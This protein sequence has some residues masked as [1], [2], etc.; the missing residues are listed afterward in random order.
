MKRSSCRDSLYLGI[1]LLA[2]TNSDLATA[3]ESTAAIQ[4]LEDITVT[5]TR[6]ASSTFEVP[7]TTSIVQ[8]RELAERAPASLRDALEEVPGLS[9]SGAGPWEA[10]PILRGFGG[11]RVLVLYDNDRVTNLWAGR[12]PL[13]PF[14]DV[15]EIERIEVIKGPASVLYG[16]DALGGVINIITKDIAYAK[17]AR[18]QMDQRFDSR[19][20]SADNGWYGGYRL[21]AGGHGL[22]MRVSVAARDHQD[23]RDGKGDELNHSQFEGQYLNVKTHYWLA[24]GQR[25]SASVRIND[26]DDFGVPQK[27]PEAPYSHFTV[28]D[29]RTYKLGYTGEALGWVEQLQA[30]AF[31]VDQD[32]QF[33]GQ[34]PSAS[35]P[36]SNR[37]ENAIDSGGIGGSLQLRLV[38]LAGHGLLAG[39]ELLRETTDSAETQRIRRD[40]NGSLARQLTFQP[41]PDAYRDYLGVFL[42]DTLQVAESLRLVAGGRY[43]YFRTDADDVTFTDE[44]F[45]KQGQRQQ[46]S[47]AVNEFSREQDSATTFSLGL[48]YKL[49][50]AVHLRS[51][52]ASAFRAPDIFE[53][54]STRGGGSRLIIGNPG[55][56]P[57]RTYSLEGGIDVRNRHGRGQ[58]SVY[59]NRVDDYIDLAI[60]E[61]SFLGE[62]PTYRYQNIQDAE[63]YG[64]DGDTSLYLTPRLT[65]TGTLAWV[66]G[67]DRDSGARLSSIPPLNGSVGLRF[68]AHWQAFRYWLAGETRLYQS[69]SNPAAGEQDTPGYATVALRLGIAR[70]HWGPLEDVRLSVN[71]ENLFDRAYQNHLRSG[72]EPFL[73][74]PGIN[75]VTALQVGF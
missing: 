73:Y 30:K 71:V 64:L 28:F 40:G 69:Q 72:Q 6:T 36:V 21:S 18:W 3:E 15:G 52:L 38:P 66:E 2:L 60:Q 26:I 22:G 25:I 42:Q 74:E 33:A 55:L 50:P 37:K 53:R 63:L 12:A 29:T 1:C 14:L 35:K 58:L 54:Y 43:D 27:D 44:R 32:R 4:T 23:Y 24:E 10:Q 11:S 19:Y 62:I 9:F 49:T 75:A 8:R 16:S 47:S 59:Y 5:A 65:L 45:N 34:F 17:D 51:T 57:E 13:T 20:S 39:V 68:D 48:L 46:S 41:V 67:K 61:A 7:T 70:A 56:D 31:Y